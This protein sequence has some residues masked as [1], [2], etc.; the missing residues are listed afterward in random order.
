MQHL[1]HESVRTQC[2]HRGLPYLNIHLLTSTHIYFFYN[3]RKEEG[4]QTATTMPLSVTIRVRCILSILSLLTISETKWSGA[5]KCHNMALAHSLRINIRLLVPSHFSF[6]KASRS[7]LKTV[8]IYCSPFKWRA[9]TYLA[10]PQMQQVHKSIQ[11]LLLLMQLLKIKM[12][13]LCVWGGEQYREVTDKLLGVVDTEKNRGLT[14][15]NLTPKNP[16]W[17][18]DSWFN[19]KRKPKGPDCWKNVSATHSPKLQL[20]WKSEKNRAGKGLHPFRFGYLPFLG[21]RW[22]PRSKFYNFF[23]VAVHKHT[24]HQHDCTETRKVVCPWLMFFA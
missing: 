3:I 23:K 22:V 17:T 5:G 12:P 9:I 14:P 13:L 2:L 24:S 8:S 18:W 4:L 6:L 19:K 11:K 20:T 10:S 16:N 21:G 15:Q 7:Q 1:P